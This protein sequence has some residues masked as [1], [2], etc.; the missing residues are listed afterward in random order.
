MPSI[1]YSSAE[2]QLM[3]L[4]N[5]HAY[6][7][8]VRRNWEYFIKHGKIDQ[9]YGLRNEVLR[10]W[11]RT[12]AKNINPYEPIDAALIPAPSLK[13]RLR[14]NEELIAVASP[15][16][17][18]F[19]ATA[20]GPEFRIDLTDKDAVILKQFGHKKNFENKGRFVIG[21]Y[22]TEESIGTNAI[23]LAVVLKQ[24]VQLI[25]PEHFNANL[26]YRTCATSPIFDEKGVLAGFINLAGNYETAHI[27][28]LGISIALARGI[29]LELR[30]KRLLNEKETTASYLNKVV[31]TIHEGVIATDQNGII[32]IFNHASSTIL[33]IPI[34]KALRK[35]IRE[36]FEKNSTIMEKRENH[37]GIIDKKMSFF[38]QN[39]RRTVKGSSFPLKGRESTGGGSLTVFKEDDISQPKKNTTGFNAHFT[40]DD[41]KGK[42]KKLLAA[43]QLAKKA[44][45][46]PSN[47]LLYGESGTGKELFA[48]A[49]HNASNFSRGPF[50][51]INC[52]A[53][54]EDL[55]ESELFGYEG[56]AFTGSR[57]EGRI[58]KFQWADGGTLFLDEI[59]SMPLSMQPKL[60]RVLQNLSFTKI[61]GNMEIPFHARIIAASNTD[62]WSEVRE[63]KFRADLFYRLDV[64]SIEIPPLRELDDIDEL[65]S[66]YCIKTTNR[67]NF[68][69]KVSDQ[70]KEILLQYSWPGNTRELK[71][72]IER[73][74]VMAL[75]RNSDCIDEEDLLS[76]RG[77]RNFLDGQ[78]T[79]GKTDERFAPSKLDSLEKK[80]IQQTLSQMKG[81][82]TKTAEHL[83][84]TRK[85]LYY[86]I[87]KYNLNPKSGN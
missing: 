31:D 55:I 85:T 25:G 77:I 48:Q 28:T 27:H 80:H 5:L 81:N 84:I 72:V 83:G 58:G 35:N 63:K 3:L 53:I 39:K 67:L 64:V 10:S 8:D 13:K 14:E 9:C 34:E 65:I 15:F 68:N 59:N 17:E 70:A 23:G 86:K 51:G 76:Y 36:V 1:N 44:A 4:S 41:I 46:I 42:S 49:I 24:P 50:V 19:T 38:Y 56:G 6:L 60:L 54:P 32:Q 45:V 43:I 62:L 29:E 78:N 82:I 21:S 33:G 30:Q 52:S 12:A 18:A 11:E 7:S 47:I 40:F 75:S 74:A 61:G 20:V 57:K 37:E 69:F 26:C 22:C 79:T 87:K 66:Y 2:Q 73:C 16:L 71:N